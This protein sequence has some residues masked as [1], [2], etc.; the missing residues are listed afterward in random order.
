MKYLK[1]IALVSDITYN[2]SKMQYLNLN[3]KIKIDN[4]IFDKLQV[5][6]NLARYYADSFSLNIIHGAIYE[7]S[8]KLYCYEENLEEI[9]LGVFKY[10]KHQINDILELNS[11]WIVPNHILNIVKEYN[12]ISDPLDKNEARIEAIE[13]IRKEVIFDIEFERQLKQHIGKNLYYMGLRFYIDATNNN[14]IKLDDLN[15][16]SVYYDFEKPEVDKRLNGMVWSHGLAA[17]NGPE[18]KSHLADLIN[19]PE[20]EVSC[21]KRNQN[22]GNIGVYVIGDVIVASHGDIYSEK[23]KKDYK[24]HWDP[25]DHIKNTPLLTKD[26]FSENYAVFAEIVVK[27]IEVVGMWIKNDFEYQKKV[28]EYK[29]GIKIYKT[30]KNRVL[31]II[32]NIKSKIL[33]LNEKQIINKTYFD[34]D[35]KELL[36]TYNYIMYYF[37]SNDIQ[38]YEWAFFHKYLSLLSELMSK[39]FDNIETDTSYDEFYADLRIVRDLR[40]IITKIALGTECFKNRKPYIKMRQEAE[41]IARAKGWPITYLKDTITVF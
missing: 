40:D 16:S 37:N 5:I 30:K 19:H 7:A 38:E 39:I 29:K 15:L 12:D 24:R 23:A 14:I 22:L 2:M 41:N 33:N 31:D 4:N 8:G 18:W 32:E 3:N 21:S 11:K 1:K 25:N 20:M 6:A 26:N 17:Y 10:Y 34:K 35:K 27:N 9:N 36:K 28:S 13:A